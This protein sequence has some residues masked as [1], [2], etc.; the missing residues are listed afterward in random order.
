MPYVDR[1][2][3]LDDSRQVWRYLDFAKFVAMLRTR[4]LH[5]TSIE[6]LRTIDPFEGYVCPET[7]EEYVIANLPQTVGGNREDLCDTIRREV[8]EGSRGA[9]KII[10][11]NC[12]HANEHESVAMWKIYADKGVAVRSTVTRLIGGLTVAEED[13]YLGEVEYVPQR[14]HSSPDLD[15][16][17]AFP[18]ITRKDLSLRHEHEIRAFCIVPN[19]TKAGVDVKVDLEE[20]I[21]KVVVSPTTDQWFHDLVAATL[22]MFHL[23]RPVDNS[24][25]KLE[26]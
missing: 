15:F 23:E 14:T 12:W 10:F 25:L 9:D 17:Y 1:G 24:Y 11:A 16:T 6:Q 19:G 21:E 26:G 22:A 8:K 2:L 4:S 7:L 5:F 18:R 3:A 20:L 13:V